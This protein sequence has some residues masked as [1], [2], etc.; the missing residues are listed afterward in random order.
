M[1]LG[2]ADQFSSRFDLQTNLTVAPSTVALS[3]SCLA[4]VSGLA[5]RAARYPLRRCKNVK[6]R[7]R[8]SGQVTQQGHNTEGASNGNCEPALQGL[9]SPRIA[10]MQFALSILG[11]GAVGNVLAPTEI[12]RDL[13]S[14]GHQFAGVWLSGILKISE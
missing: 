13:L 1:V 12:P 9:V 7:I 14:M 4:F 2:I 6:P 11:L 3:L 8:P 10:T 5:R